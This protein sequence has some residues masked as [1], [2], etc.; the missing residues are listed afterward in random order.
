MKKSIKI[1]YILPLLLLAFSC[2]DL[3][4]PIASSYTSDVFP[5][6]ELEFASVTGPVYVQLRN[7]IALDYFYTQ[8]LTTDEAVLTARGADYYDG[9]RYL[10][11]NLHTWDE[12]HPFLGS[13]WWWS[14]R[15]VSLCGEILEALSNAPESPFKDKTIAEIKTMRALFYFFAMDNFGDIPIAPE[16]GVVEL[17]SQSPRADVFRYIENEILEA[18][19]NLSKDNTQSTY[20]KPTYWMA[21]ALL[22][23]LYMNAEVYTGTPMYNEAIVAINQILNAQANGAP[24]AFDLEQNFMKIF[25]VDNGPHIKE[26]IFAVPF[27]QNFGA[28]GMRLG[29][30]PLHPLLRVNYGLPTSISVGNCLSTWADFYY[31]Y[32]EENDTRQDTWLSGLQYYLDGSPVMDGTYH[33][34]LDPEIAFVNIETFDRGRSPQQIAQGARNVKYTP[35]ATWTSSRDSRNDFVLF[36]YADFVLLKAEAILRGGT[37]PSGENALSLVNQVRTIRNTEP[38]TSIDME[39]LFEERSRE[40]A[41]E[42]WRR[43]DLIRFGKWESTWGRDAATG[44]PV[45]TNNEVY[46]RVFPIPQNELASNPKLVQ[47]DGY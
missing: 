5:R 3:D 38:F 41:Y 28:N 43:N 44:L 12:T 9:G 22:A 37:D 1:Q 20:G 10:E 47:N 13:I 26:I 30:F 7:T 2:T 33:V 6:T 36:R 24:S 46:R 25:D 42:T 15:G 31:L 4:V 34:N 27:D 14:F 32:E 39:T 17:P 11:L 29:R 21:Q 40:M 8:E 19:P 16:Y 35:D 18:I 45:K 23:K